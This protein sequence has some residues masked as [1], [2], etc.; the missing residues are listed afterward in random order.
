[1]KSCGRGAHGRLS[2]GRNSVFVRARARGPVSSPASQL[3]VDHTLKLIGHGKA[4]PA[5]CRNDQ[6]PEAHT[7][8]RSDLS[9]EGPLSWRVPLRKAS[10]RERARSDTGSRLLFGSWPRNRYGQN[11]HTAKFTIVTRKA[12]THM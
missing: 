2:S 7:L 9:G 11:N 4:G 8:I 12:T 10:I 1:M 6:L 5:H 3:S